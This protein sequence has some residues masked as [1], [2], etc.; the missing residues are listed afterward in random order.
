M[1][2]MS[3]VNH[4]HLIALV[5]R[6]LLSWPRWSLRLRLW[7]DQTIT[8]N[9]ERSMSM[10]LSKTSC[11]CLDL[12]IHDEKSSWTPTVGLALEASHH[13]GQ[14]DFQFTSARAN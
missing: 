14:V 2:R 11:E 13:V 7:I 8:L 10:P 1:S 12:R 3:L 6:I 5:G 9:F 4:W